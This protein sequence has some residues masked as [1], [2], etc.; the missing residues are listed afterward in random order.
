MTDLTLLTPPGFVSYSRY[1]GK[2]LNLTIEHYSIY[3]RMRRSQYLLTLLTILIY[4]YW[5]GVFLQNDIWFVR[6]SLW[7]NNTLSLSKGHRRVPT[8]ARRIG[9]QTRGTG[10]RHSVD[11]TGTKVKPWLCFF[12]LPLLNISNVAIWHCWAAGAG[13]A[14][15]CGTPSSDWHPRS[16]CYSM[17]SHPSA[18]RSQL[19]LLRWLAP[20]KR[21]GSVP[22]AN[23][24]HDGLFPGS[25]ILY[26]GA[27]FKMLNTCVHERRRTSNVSKPYILAA[28]SLL[29]CKKHNIFKLRRVWIVCAT[30][31]KS[32]FCSNKQNEP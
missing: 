31:F 30:I 1:K 14:A 2:G 17:P 7:P 19:Q 4:L 9:C 8:L 28:L 11:L 29:R 16:A 10:P 22:H 27:F 3:C 12:P 32:I 26:F 6:W 13:L 5:L 20:M 25:H 24:F 15:E 23:H 18:D 21:D